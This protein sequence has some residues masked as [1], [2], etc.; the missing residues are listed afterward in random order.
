MHY[1]IGDWSND[2]LGKTPCAQEETEVDLVLLSVKEL[3]FGNGAHYKDICAKALQVGLELGPAARRVA[4]R[5][6][7]GN[8]RLGRR[9]P[10]LRGGLR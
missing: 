7:G 5:R 6:N 1:R 3:G 10:R 9:P 4:P 8:Y 2:A